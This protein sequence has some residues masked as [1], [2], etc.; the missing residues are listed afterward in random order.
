VLAAP[1]GPLGAED[2]VRVGLL[3]KAATVRVLR[4]Y[5]NVVSATGE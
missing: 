4:A 2:H 5:E 1:G 3:N